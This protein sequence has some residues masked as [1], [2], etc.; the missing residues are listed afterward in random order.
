[1]R[2]LLIEDDPLIGNGLELGLNKLG[3]SVDWFKDGKSGFTALDSAPYDAVVLDST[4]PKM[5]GLDILHQWR[6]L[7]KNTPVLILTARDTLDE[8]IKGLNLGAD[9]YLCKPFALKEV[10]AR[11][12]ALIRRSQGNSSPTIKFG[13]LVLDPT[14][15]TLFA[16]DQEINLTSR[17]YRLAELFMTSK[18][19]VLPRSLIEEKLHSW[20][21]EISSNAL[22]VHIHNLR[23]KVGNTFIRTIHGVGYTLGKEDEN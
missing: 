5:D 21:D 3:M 4:L 8:R 17:E 1:M 22:E 2:I 12:A 19:R 15:R 20:S 7:N 6:T 16:D 10:Q 9:D 13:R 14:A 23:K 11:L 18:G